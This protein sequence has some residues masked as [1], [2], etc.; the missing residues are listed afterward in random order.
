MPDRKRLSCKCDPDGVEFFCH[1]TDRDLVK[2]KQE[3]PEADIKR[4]DT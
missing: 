1:C 4:W 2:W 3:H